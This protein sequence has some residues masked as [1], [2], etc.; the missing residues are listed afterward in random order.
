MLKISRSLHIKSQKK[1]LAKSKKKKKWQKIGE[2]KNFAKKKKMANPKKK[3]RNGKK[4][5]YEK[6]A[7]K[8]NWQ[9]KKKRKLAKNWRPN[10][11]NFPT[12][13]VRRRRRRG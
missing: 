6:L 9:I 11:A 4:I 7:N 5:G 2:Q 3:K 8:K 1:K 10:F 12:S 13:V